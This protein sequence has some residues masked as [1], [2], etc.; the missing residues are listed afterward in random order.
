MLGES[1]LPHARLVAEQVSVQCVM[2][3]HC[4]DMAG[5]MRREDVAQLADGTEPRSKV[6]VVPPLA[7]SNVVPPGSEQHAP[8]PVVL[9]VDATKLPQ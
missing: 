1:L 5:S 9:T 6:N 2:D 4:E 3:V 7:E 8:S